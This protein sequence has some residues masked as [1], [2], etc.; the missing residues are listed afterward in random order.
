[1]LS[2]SPPFS[3]ANLQPFCVFI[4]NFDLAVLD[5]SMSPQ[6]R[7]EQKQAHSRSFEVRLSASNQDVIT[8]TMGD[9]CCLF[10]APHLH[11]C[12]Q[13]RLQWQNANLAMAILRCWSGKAE[14]GQVSRL[15]IQYCLC[16]ILN[17]QLENQTPGL[18]R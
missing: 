13:E 18:A 11:P 3:V 9:S 8:E 14:V 16:V 12:R 7:Q 6:N 1:M 5:K 4:F 10:E 15:L 2:L 17:A